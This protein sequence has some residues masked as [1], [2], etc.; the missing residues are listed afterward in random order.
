[1]HFIFDEI[2]DNSEKNILEQG[3]LIKRT[4]EI[5]KTLINIHPH[6]GTHADY[7]YFII[8]TQSCDL[9]KH[10]GKNCKTHYIT[11]AAVRPFKTIFYRNLKNFQYS[12]LE[13]KLQYCS[14]NAREKMKQFIIKLYN[15]NL[16]GFF[17]LHYDPILNI[18]EPMVAFLNLSIA[19]KA[20]LHYEKC[21]SARITR[22]K[23]EFKAKLGWLVGNLYSRIGTPDWV[24]TY[25]TNPKEFD[26][27]IEELLDLHCTWVDAKYRK[28]IEKFQKEQQEQNGKDYELS[29][30]ELINYVDYLKEAEKKQKAEN[31]NKIFNIFSEYI[32]ELK[33]KDE[34]KR[35]ISNKLKND[36]T[37]SQLFK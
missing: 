16:P 35:K 18:S 20:D 34:I 30:Q 5:E 7:K 13:K 4:S 2:Q 10:N 19:L 37:L 12:E 29:K 32:P 26:D 28:K 33:I 23:P 31:I 36:S 21:L 27:K 25:Y 24:P 15:N 22:L 6:Y 11:L 1:M 3:D 14:D 17:Y 9:Y 8:L